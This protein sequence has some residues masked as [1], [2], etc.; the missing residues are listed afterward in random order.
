MKSV[1]S[2]SVTLISERLLAKRPVTR[3]I[4]TVTEQKRNRRI[5]WQSQI[6]SNTIF[7]SDHWNCEEIADVVCKRSMD[8]S[9]KK[10]C[11]QSYI[12]FCNVFLKLP[13]IFCLLQIN[14]LKYFLL[15]F[16]NL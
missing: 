10:I 1:V 6:M 7:L 2:P 15:V 11:F 4:D 12:D 5:S 13:L 14:K 9:F 8:Q 16:S 3:I